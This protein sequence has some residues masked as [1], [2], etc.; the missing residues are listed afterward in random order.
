MPISPGD[1]FKLM[2]HVGKI[3][4][5][6]SFKNA[7]QKQQE[8]DERIGDKALYRAF[9]RWRAG[10][11][12]HEHN[13]S[14]FFKALQVAGWPQGIPTPEALVRRNYSVPEFLNICKLSYDNVEHLLSREAKDEWS[15]GHYNLH[16]MKALDAQSKTARAKALLPNMV[17]TYYLYRRH[18]MLPGVLRETFIIDEVKDAHC[19]GWYLQYARAHA[20]NVIPFNAFFCEFYVIAFGAHQALG[21]RTEIVT[22]SVLL[23]NAFSDNALIPCDEHNRHFLGILTGIY[24]YGNVL[25]AERVLIERHRPEVLIKKKQCEGGETKLV[26]GKWGPIHIHRDSEIEFR[27]EYSKVIDVIDNSLDGQTL[28]ARSDRLELVRG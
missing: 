25:L 7:F 24:D 21:R 13:E 9:R 20:P 14:C 3:E 2:C 15:A 12:M 28:T 8:V 10:D 17:G 18:S 27:G 26:V 4:K 22:V 1:R 11:S 5:F 23:E 19:E 6:R 16:F